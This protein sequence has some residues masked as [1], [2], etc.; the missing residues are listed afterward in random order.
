MYTVT[1]NPFLF[2]AGQLI[3][4]LEVKP[5][6]TVVTHDHIIPGL[7]HETFAKEPNLF[8]SSLLPAVP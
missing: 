4:A 2:F 8:V 7:W 3:D 6:L 5:L 1:A